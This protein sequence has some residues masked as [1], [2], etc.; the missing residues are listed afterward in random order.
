M[1][2]LN[3]FIY[4]LTISVQPTIHN[5]QPLVPWHV[6]S[7]PWILNLPREYRA[8]RNNCGLSRWKVCV[9]AR[10]WNNGT[11]TQRPLS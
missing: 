6:K 9:V 7:K 5:Y 1:S 2:P 3:T 8:T 4:N 11:Q 10:I